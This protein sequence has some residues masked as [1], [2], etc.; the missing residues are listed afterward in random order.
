[1]ANHAETTK[2]PLF[3]CSFPG[4][5]MVLKGGGSDAEG[6]ATR[7]IHGHLTQLS[8]N[9]APPCS[10]PNCVVQNLCTTTSFPNDFA[11]GKTA[12]MSL[13][14]HMQNHFQFKCTFPAIG[15]KECGQII[16]QHATATGAGGKAS[17]ISHIRQHRLEIG[18]L[19]EENRL[20]F[21]LTNYS[22]PSRHRYR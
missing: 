16:G 1:M 9:Q 18:M 7:H 3:A 22:S 14:D 2:P 17:A 11:S 8:T 20:D 13:Y 10:V 19:Y 4:C 6:Y 5:T 12:A 15:G 21:V